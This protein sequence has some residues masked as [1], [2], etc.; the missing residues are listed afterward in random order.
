ML[1]QPSILYVE[2]DL[3]SRM[4]ME[5]LLVEDMGLSYV[6]ILEDSKDFL[7]KVEALEPAADVVLLD[8]HVKPYNGFEMLGILRSHPIYKDTPVVALT[9]SAASTNSGK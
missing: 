5:I 7:S 4:V 1:Q 6:T 3:Q 8:I 2:D 9:A